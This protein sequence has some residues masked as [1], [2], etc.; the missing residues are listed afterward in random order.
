M[1]ATRDT[2]LDA[3][4][5]LAIVLMVMCHAGAAAGVHDFVYLFHMPLFFLAAGWC[6]RFGQV[7]TLSG[8]GGGVCSPPD[9]PPLFA[10]RARRR[11]VCLGA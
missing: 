9:I 3:V 4:K 7:A 2:A 6:Y 1:S 5:G 11:R 8:G 10:V